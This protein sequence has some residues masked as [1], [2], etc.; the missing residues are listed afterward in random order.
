M[1]EAVCPRGKYKTTNRAAYNAALKSRGSLTILLDRDMQ[2]LAVPNGRR[3]RQRVFS[4]TAIQF[5]LSI[6]CLFDL[7]LR[8]SLGLVESLL[9][10][11]RLDW[12]VHDYSNISCRQQSLRV[13]LQYRHQWRKVHLAIDAHT[14]EVR[15]CMRL[16]RCLWK[17]WIGC[18]RRVWWR[19]RRIASN[20]WASG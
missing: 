11:P 20:G 12:P 13:Q 19:P 10:L 1:S 16:G 17:R 4:E 15:A 5:C 14:F 6:K 3:G 7:A 18:H 9:R 2:C 8:Q